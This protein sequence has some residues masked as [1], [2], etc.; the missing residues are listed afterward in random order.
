[1][2]ESTPFLP[3]L[4][5]VAGKPL[6]ATFDG[7]H[8]SSDG[9]V[10]VLREIALKLGIAQVITLPLPDVRDPLRITHT[11]AD[12]ALVRM[13]LIA[14]GY[15]DC[16]DAD[17]L[18]T[19][20]AMKIACGR[21][22]E[23]GIDLMSQP[24]LS[25]L[26]NVA[27]GTSLYRI[28]RGLIDLFCRS[29]KD[30]PH[31]IILDIDDTDDM[32][33]GQQEFAL[34][35]THAGGHCF[36]P[37]LI[38]EGTTGKPILALHR[39]GK[40]PSGEEVARVLRHVIHRIRRHFPKVRILVRGDSHY[41]AGPVLALL[42]ATRC[43]YILGLSTNP[44]LAGIAAPWKAK[45]DARRSHTKRKIR[46][47]HQLQYQAR[48]WSR[49]HKVIARVEATDLGTDV[50]FV[51]TNLAGR[52]KHL[53][54][55]VYC[56]RGRM[57]NLIKDLKLYTRSDKTACTRWQANQFRL[58]LHMGAYWLLHTLRRTASRRS[59]WRGATFD[60]I[61]RTFVKIAVRVEELKTRIK[62]SFP[63][64][65]PQAEALSLICDRIT[66]RGS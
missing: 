51:V 10:I 35:N 25:R 42:I 1:M 43:D 8:L 36:K 40:R 62:L 23:T 26:E 4:S 49:S 59:V 65:C 32:V 58:F 24:T 39:P 34:F 17:A 54:D 27:D 14:A 6:T 61:R 30:A 7:G 16:D 53:Y 50:R 13:I 66:A 57:E 11:Y 41:C 45:C 21:A 37:M 18:R 55:K 19:D 2:R 20:P 31:R 64:S 56:Q 44:K 60:T 9:G 52:A 47:F 12:M 3:G 29:Y 33:H 46:R 15:E 5:P 38:F 63:T 48:S 22:P 28:G